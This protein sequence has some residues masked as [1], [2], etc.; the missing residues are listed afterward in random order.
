[1]SVRAI[2]RVR[3][4]QSFFLCGQDPVLD[5][6][7]SLSVS[8]C[9]FTPHPFLS[10]PSSSLSRPSS[11]T[12]LYPTFLHLTCP[13]PTLLFPTLLFPTLLS[14]VIPQLEM[15]IK[16]KMAPNLVDRVDF[17]PE[18]EV[19]VDLVAY[20]LKVR[21]GGRSTLSSVTIF[22]PSSSYY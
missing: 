5:L 2:F 14:Q 9:P 21:G 10:L 4:W 18:A 6:L 16:Q 13:H 7:Y 11:T 17:N 1:M 8:F 3:I 15:I 12:F 22:S 19:F 20:A